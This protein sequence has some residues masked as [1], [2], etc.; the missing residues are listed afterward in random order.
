[1]SMSKEQFDR[2]A[3]GLLFQS[4]TDAP[5]TYYE[6]ELDPERSQQWPPPTAGQFLELIG[7]DPAAPVE[8][9]APEKFFGDLRPGNEDRADQVADLQRT[10]KE[11]LKN[12][13]GF[14]VGKIQI[15]IFVL[16]TDND[17][18][19]GLQTLSVET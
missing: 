10:L 13:A 9:L 3:E 7:E 14:R 19:V 4:E 5:L 6:L 2:L 12:L 1:M 8:E 18:V 17:K 16:G 15:K 11:G